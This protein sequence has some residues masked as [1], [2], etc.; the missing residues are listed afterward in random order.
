MVRRFEGSEVIG[1]AEDRDLTAAEYGFD[2][3]L[4]EEG[5][6]RGADLGE[7]E[8]DGC[9]LAVDVEVAPEDE[10][11]REGEERVDEGVEEGGDDEERVADVGGE[12]AKGGKG[13]TAP[14][15]G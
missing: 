4:D 15:G 11:C 8:G 12:L 3:E 10:G 7:G 5:D 14:V 2:R 9:S 6:G 13:A 1:C